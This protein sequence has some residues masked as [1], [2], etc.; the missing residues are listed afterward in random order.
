MANYDPGL[1]GSLSSRENRPTTHHALQDWSYRMPS[2]PRVVVPLAVLDRHFCPE[3]EAEVKLKP[4]SSS[5]YP[6][7]EFG[8]VDFLGA[9]P[10]RNM[11]LGTDQNDWTYEKRRQAQRIGPF[12]YLGP[13]GAARDMA[14]LREEGI[15]ML[16]AVR[17]TISAQAGLLN[18]RRTAAAL[19]IDFN[20]VD[21]TGGPEL[22]AS[23]PR[24]IR[25][26]NSHMFEMYSRRAANLSANME[27]MALREG[28]GDEFGAN[29]GAVLVYC[30]TGNER[31]AA[32]VT[33]YLI[34][35]FSL[36]ISQAVQVITAKRFCIA[37]DDDMKRLLTSYVDLLA[38]KREVMR[39]RREQGL[40]NAAM[41]AT[42][43]TGES[44]MTVGSKRNLDEVYDTE[45]EDWGATGTNG[46][47]DHER[48]LSRWSSAPFDDIDPS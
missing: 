26:I 25:M 27:D 46:H 20:S 47:F 39:Y 22:I 3:R 24:A 13:A 45:M 38:A 33:A 1:G 41:A 2:P 6:D 5:T 35:M 40:A 32:V 7:N 48:Y 29:F 15:T 8:P 17:S 36:T 37:L 30:E 11:V 12:L 43:V 19:G 14:F 31:S 18:C 42:M 10:Q 23:F 16:L 21:V 28:P 4:I 34:A 9:F 44:S